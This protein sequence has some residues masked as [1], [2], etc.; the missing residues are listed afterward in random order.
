MA[1]RILSPAMRATPSA[2][3]RTTRSFQTSTRRLADA[4]PLPVRKPVGAFRGGLF[5]F[6]LGSTLAGAGV[7]YYILEEYK[8]SNGLLTEDIYSLQASVQRVHSYVQTLE[9]KLT[10]L[11]KKKK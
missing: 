8:V 9:E 7:Y 6:L 4:T 5:G 10:E 1:S 3:L 2:A 11:E